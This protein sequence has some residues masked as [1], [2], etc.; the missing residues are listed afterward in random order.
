MATNGAESEKIQRPFPI[1]HSVDW[2]ALSMG[3][4]RKATTAIK[5]SRNV[6][7]VARAG[8]RGIRC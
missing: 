7:V 3:L 2:M 5:P 6:I 4:V 1:N 8:Q